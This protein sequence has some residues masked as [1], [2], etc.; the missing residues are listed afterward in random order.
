M[1]A[2]SCWLLPLLW[3]VGQLTPR[4]QLTS[5][6]GEAGQAP[7]HVPDPLQ[8]CIA[9]RS[10]LLSLSPGHSQTL[11]KLLRLQMRPLAVSAGNTQAVL[12]HQLSKHTTQNPFRKNRGRV[13]RVLFHPLKPFLFLATQNHIRVYNLAQQGLAKKLVGGS[14]G[15]TSMAIHPGGD[16]VIVGSEVRLT[17][18]V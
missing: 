17:T 14:G 12:V 9:S 6:G 13:V 10:D 15:I 3:F 4:G 11:Q 2:Q 18:S 5:A 8:P 16:H 1:R 7:V